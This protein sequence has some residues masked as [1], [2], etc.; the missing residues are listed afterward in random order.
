MAIYD[1]FQYFD[2]D[3][4]VDLRLNILNEYVDYFVISESTKTHQG[5]PKKINFDLNNFPKFKDKIKFILADY[6][7]DIFFDK[8]TGGESPIEQHQRNNLINGIKNADSED[9]IILSD[10]DEIPDMSKFKKIEKNKKYIA[11][12]QKMFMYKLNLQNLNESGWIGSKITKKKYLYS[13]QDL[14]NLK[15]KNYPFWR[16]DKK[17]LQIIEGGW[18][19]SFLKTPQQILKKIK[20]FSHGEFNDSNLS[21][22]E[23]EEK[24]YQNKDI[25]SRGFNLQKIDIDETFPKYIYEN[26][27]KLSK[28]II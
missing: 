22:K 2:E 21:E 14:R 15:F 7:E 18:H 25:F 27:S 13:M 10:T 3:H 19:F 4:L 12:S 16:F 11:F 17:A 23:I 26:K 1:C 6:N 5:K 9:Y 24:I 28:W 20:S 8:H